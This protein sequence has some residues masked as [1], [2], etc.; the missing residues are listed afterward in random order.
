MLP[1]VEIFHSIQGE[2]KYTGCPS[3]FIRVTGC[4]LRCVFKDT[5]CDTS[6]TS[7][8]PEKP[9]YKDIRDVYNEAIRLFAQY[10]HTRHIVLTG[11]E[12]L[13]YRE[14]IKRLIEL[15]DDYDELI[16]F[17]YTIE[18]NGTLPPIKTWMSKALNGCYYEHSI[19]LHSVSPKLSTSVDHECKYLTKE[20][21]DRHN[22]TRINLH[23]LSRFAYLCLPSSN[24]DVQ[25]KFVYSNED[26]VKEIKELITEIERVN[27]Q[28]IN[29][30]SKISLMPE[31]TTN[32]KL[33]DIQLEC[34]EVCRREGWRFC[35]RL[36][37]RIWGDKRK[38]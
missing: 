5:I 9:I 18:T 26:S 25:F 30:S 22:Y 36:H 20:Q 23:S 10:P 32:D 7:F 15:L 14:D 4:N 19:D 27:D 29:I 33:N 6:Y 35:D 21:R 34:V 24:S 17:V 3:I 37:I 31:G 16:E 13:L 38:V 28:R 8:N 11:G 1:V 2:G 12:P